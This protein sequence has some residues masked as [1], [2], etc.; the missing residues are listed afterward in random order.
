MLGGRCG[1]IH[2][3]HNHA[4]LCSVVRTPKHPERQSLMRPL[5]G[6]LSDVLTFG[7]CCIPE[8]SCIVVPT[9]A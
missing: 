4:S 2:V 7:C 1:F 9:S 8:R 6:V 3:Y 5:V